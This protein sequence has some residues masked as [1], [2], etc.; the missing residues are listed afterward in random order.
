LG[1]VA[2]HV[3]EV[4]N[5]SAPLCKSLTQDVQFETNFEQELHLESQALHSF[6]SL[7]SNVPVGHL[8][9]HRP[10]VFES[11]RPSEQ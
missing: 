11:R 5:K 4:R 10:N 2:T 8:T 7:D 9:E 6:E 1:Q 3:Y